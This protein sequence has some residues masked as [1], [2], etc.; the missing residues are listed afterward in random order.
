MVAMSGKGQ[1]PSITSSDVGEIE[2]PLPPLEIQQQIVAEIDSYQKEIQ[3]LKE[4]IKK[5]EAQ[6]AA[7]I[8]SV[9]GVS[10]TNTTQ[11]KPYSTPETELSVAAEE[12]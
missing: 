8:N 12:G 6:I 11:P 4:E 2:I 10:T 7:K 5:K 3:D 9:W 1:Y